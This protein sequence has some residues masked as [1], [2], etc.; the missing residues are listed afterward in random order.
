METKLALHQVNSMFY[1][2]Q[3]HI[4]QNE[5][6]TEQKTMFCFYNFFLVQLYLFS[7]TLS[8]SIYTIL[9]GL[10]VYRLEYKD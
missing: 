5:Y 3:H 8:S 4:A 1:C 9:E 6:S 10:H 2:Y 7:I